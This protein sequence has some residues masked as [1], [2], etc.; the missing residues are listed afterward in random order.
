MVVVLHEPRLSDGD[1]TYRVDVLNGTLPATGGPCSLFIDA[2]GRS[3]APV[4]VR[5]LRR[6]RRTSPSQAPA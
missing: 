2:F 5:G 6:P 3:L 4:S 1:L